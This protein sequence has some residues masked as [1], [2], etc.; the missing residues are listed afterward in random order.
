AGVQRFRH[1]SAGQASG[2]PPSAKTCG[3]PRREGDIRYLSVT[4]GGTPL[5][6]GDSRLPLRGFG[7]CSTFFSDDKYSAKSTRSCVDRVRG[8]PAGMMESFCCSRFVTSAF[9]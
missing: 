7:Y 5:A 1:L 6:L 9:L 3:G 2:L 8:R 4:Q